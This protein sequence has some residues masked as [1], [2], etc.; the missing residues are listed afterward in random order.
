MQ[1]SNLAIRTLTA[2]IGIPTILLS[3]FNGG[4]YL[5]LLILFCAMMAQ[6]EFYRLVE[7]KGAKPQKIVGLISGA[8]LIIAFL[9]NKIEILLNNYFEKLG[10]FIP[11]PTQMQ[12][13]TIILL[14]STIT[15]LVFEMFR[16]NGSAITNIATTI[17][18]IL[19]ISLLFGTLVGIRE[20]FNITEFPV[21]KYFVMLESSLNLKEEV[22]R[23]GGYTV[24]SIFSI[25]W[26]CDTMAY[27]GGML[28]GKHKLFE[29]VSPNKTWEGAFFGFIFAIISAVSAKYLL[30]E[31]LTLIDAIMIGFIIGTLGQI[32]DLAE[33]LIK[34]DAGVKDSSSII[35]GHGGFLDRFDS[36][37]FVSPILYLYFDLI[38]LP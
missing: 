10:I 32:G 27:F 8:F 14:L 25:I 31:Y 21:Q 19:Y 29:R 9:H 16:N 7:I 23:W 26:I 2:L 5:L 24:A 15:I 37:I 22:Y 3:A 36:L 28:L 6:Y 38:I 13:I 20:L 30:L 17:L 33:S 35:P 34:R 4:V 1:L 12:L 18:G 11:Y